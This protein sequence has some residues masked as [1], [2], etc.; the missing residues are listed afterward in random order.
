MSTSAT[1]P[2]KE[3]ADRVAAAAAAAPAS[4]AAQKTGAASS[5]P[6]ASP[7]A[8]VAKSTP[9][10][11]D[12][13]NQTIRG[14][15]QTGFI[16]T[17][18]GSV[19]IGEY[20]NLKHN[21]RT[22]IPIQESLS[23]FQIWVLSP[24]LNAFMWL[25]T[26]VFF[27]EVDVIGLE[28]IPRTGPVVFYGN[29]QNQFMDA[30]MV[31]A[32]CGRP[33]RFIIAEKSLHRPI[34]GHFARLMGAVPVVRPQDVASTTGTG[35]IVSLTCDTVIGADTKF[36]TEVHIGDVLQW[37][38]VGS[39]E[40]CNAQVRSIE[41]DTKVLLT[42]PVEHAQEVTKPTTF[43]VSRRIDHSEMYGAVYSTLEADGAIGVFPEGGS[44]DR[45]SLLPLKAGVALFSLGAAERGINPTIIP[46][47][48]TYFYGHKFRSRAHIEFGKPILPPPDLVR[49]FSTDKRATTAAFL[50]L[51]EGALRDVTINCEDWSCLKFIHSFRR[52]YQDPSM[53]LETID[54]LR[55]TRRLARI[56]T[57]HEQDPDFA[58][59]R[60]R[61]ENYI[62]FCN[63]LFVRDAQ[64]ATLSNLKANVSV[65]LL[66]R[67][68][69]VLVVLLFTLVPFFVI[70]GPVGI[71]LQV[72]SKAHARTA[73]LSST[74]K[75]VGAD[76]QASYKII[77]GFALFPVVMCGVSFAVYWYGG[78]AR[79]AAT[80]FLCLP[81]AMYVSLFLVHEFILELY[82][83][84]PLFMSLVSN[85]KQFI[86]L[87]ERRTRLV[88]MATAMVLRFD[89]SLHAEMGV[90]DGSS[91]P[92]AHAP[93]FFSLRHRSRAS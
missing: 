60:S 76:V 73:L 6:S 25:L 36:A 45:T 93:S 68:V 80:V 30:V 78:D 85:H 42:L 90:Y 9:A 55:L 24:L 91:S 1:T 83:A 57:D 15:R 39:S 92:H 29:H 18:H 81:M 74:V 43:Q 54:Y 10:N 5:P 37:S 70:A 4:P 69:V 51:L 88:Q 33:V 40:K 77:G 59:F 52:L 26:N 38:V 56:A 11:D 44:H 14:R 71:I 64:A 28:N 89:P 8:V 82:A 50:G 13:H 27:R 63:A 19:P 23:L 87:H 61:V 35:K 48:L 20:F 2:E 7:A 62:D 34:I 65:V 79:S 31:R 53:R 3:S 75:I 66:F 32:H 16:E 86:K 49:T 17:D 41:S 84:L 67:R 46:V 72:A 21:L 12:Q 47:G 22:V 58:E